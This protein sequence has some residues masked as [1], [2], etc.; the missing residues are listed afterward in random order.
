MPGI[1][2]R[3]TVRVPLLIS[4]RAETSI[5][6]FH[7]QGRDISA[8]G[9]GVYLKRFPPVGSMVELRLKL[10]SSDVKV[11][12]AGEVVYVKR[13]DPA[14][15]WMGVKFTRMDSASLAEIQRFVSEGSSKGGAHGFA[16]PPLPSK[17]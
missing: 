2:Q 1:E 13:G 11:E 4:L 7:G 17:R 8:G 10:P 5:G 3:K 12:I 6:T 14:N 15:T 9:I 16:P